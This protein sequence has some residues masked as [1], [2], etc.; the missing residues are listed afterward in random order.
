MRQEILKFIKNRNGYISGEE[1]SRHFNISRAGIWKQIQGLRKEGYEIVAVPHLG[2]RLEST[3]DKLLPQEVSFGLNTKIIGKY[4]HHF[5]CVDSTMDVAFKLG[6]SG[7]PEGTVVC[8]ET[9]KKGRGRMG[10]SWLSPKSKGIYASIILRPKLLPNET[11][12]LTLL[13]A[14]AISE[15]IRDMTGLFSY[16]KWPNDILINDRKLGGILTEIDA[17]MDI[18][19]FAIIGLG[20]NVNAKSSQLPPRATSISQEKGGVFSRVEL[21]REILRKLDKLYL[22]LQRQGFGP[23]IER[24]R[25]LSSTIGRRVKVSYKREHIEGEAI[26]VDLDGGLLIRSDYGFIEKIMAGDVIKVR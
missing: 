18:V 15:A 8:A 2:Y 6:I 25:E 19:K 12:R 14:V 17:E 13:S 1:I 10:R 21:L 3:P 26:D 7:Y 20:I 4:I 16:I 11:A 24:W 22:L 23:V 9:Q 5:D